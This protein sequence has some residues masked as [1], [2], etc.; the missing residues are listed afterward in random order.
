MMPKKDLAVEAGRPPA[1]PVPRAPRAAAKQNPVGTLARE[2]LKNGKDSTAVLRSSTPMSSSER[3]RP[4]EDSPFAR[5]S[6]LTRERESAEN[7]MFEHGPARTRPA[8]A[9]RSGLHGRGHV[10]G[11]EQATNSGMPWG[12]SDLKD[13]DALESKDGHARRSTLKH[14]RNAADQTLEWAAAA[15]AEEGA[16]PLQP[17]SGQSQQHRS[18]GRR[19]VLAQEEAV[20]GTTSLGC[21]SVAAAAPQYHGRRNVL[22]H[23]MERQA[24]PVC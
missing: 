9:G 3:R 17:P 15:P 10:L 23:E 2:G 14:E 8:S 19:S 11:K 5:I 20:P 24:A 4:R 16:P 22:R 21:C 18:H 13:I 1:A 6:S 12:K 7:Q